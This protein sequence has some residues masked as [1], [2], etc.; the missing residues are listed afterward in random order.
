MAKRT[1]IEW[2]DTMGS[3]VIVLTLLVPVV[4]YMIFVGEYGLLASYFSRNPIGGT[5]DTIL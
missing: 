3:V 4:F 5:G 1:E 2:S